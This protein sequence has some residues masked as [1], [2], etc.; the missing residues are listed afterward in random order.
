MW[1]LAGTGGGQLGKGARG[2]AGGHV[3]IGVGGR[4]LAALSLPQNQ[5]APRMHSVCGG[6]H[7]RLD[8]T[9]SAAGGGLLIG[10]GE[11]G[12][13]AEASSLTV[14]HPWGQPQFLHHVYLRGEPAQAM[15]S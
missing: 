15:G 11:G 7:N 5:F 14:H 10:W 12:H 2:G 6:V 3:G 8:R 4:L 9:S 13:L 1:D